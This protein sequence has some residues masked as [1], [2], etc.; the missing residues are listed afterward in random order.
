MVV[1]WKADAAGGSNVL[2]GVEEPAVPPGLGEGEVL[3]RI[4]DGI[5]DVTAAAV[6]LKG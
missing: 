2:Y 6:F 3:V 1:V 5:D 4:P